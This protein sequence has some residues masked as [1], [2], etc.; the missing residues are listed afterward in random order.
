VFSEVTRDMNV[1][2]LSGWG[3]KA[4]DFDEFHRAE[5][6]ARLESGVND[7]VTWD[8]ECAPRS[9]LRSLMGVLTVML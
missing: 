7:K 4:W 6:P 5:L 3:L 8:L 9:Q 2:D 1:G